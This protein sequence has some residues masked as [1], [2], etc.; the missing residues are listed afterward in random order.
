[1]KKLINLKFDKIIQKKISNN[2]SFLG[3]CVGYQ[4]LFNGSSEHGMHEGLNIIK[5]KFVNFIDE[6]KN[7]K[8]PHVGWNECKLINKNELFYE[9]KDNSD[10]YFTHSYILKDFDKENIAS[11]TN[12]IV[13]FVSAVNFKNVYGVQ[14][15]PEKS[16]LNGLK[17]LKNFNERC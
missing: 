4:V 14:F 8:I 15:H 10:F 9:I 1:M 16:Q 3:I 17:L 5:G 6:N 13:D 2:C 7:I 12:Y 11:K